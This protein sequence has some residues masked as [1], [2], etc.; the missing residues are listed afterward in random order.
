MSESITELGDRWRRLQSETEQARLA[1]RDAL[2]AELS[3]ALGGRHPLDDLAHAITDVTGVSS[4]SLRATIRTREIADARLAF[5]LL[6]THAGH[7]AETIGTYLGRERSS[8]SHGT[9]AAWKMVD[10]DRHF[11]AMVEKIK[12]LVAS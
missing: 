11:A 2:R 6:A 3:T 7:G 10:T 8:V 5:Y 12:A 4:E 9:S 1:Y